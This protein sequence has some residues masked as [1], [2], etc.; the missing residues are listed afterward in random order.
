MGIRH[1]KSRVL[2]LSS[3][4]GAL[5]DIGGDPTGQNSLKRLSV[6]VILNVASM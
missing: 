3:N 5:I 4:A 6:Q 2:A 1:G